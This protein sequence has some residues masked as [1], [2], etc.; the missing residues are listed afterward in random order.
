MI[1]KAGESL[2][3]RIG[4]GSCCRASGSAEVLAALGVNIDADVVEPSM[5]MMM[6][7]GDDEDKADDAETVVPYYE[8]LKE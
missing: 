4:L 3:I 8:N 7:G 5:G 2:E 6:G 1:D